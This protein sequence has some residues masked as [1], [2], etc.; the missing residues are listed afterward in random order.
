MICWIVGLIVGTMP[1]MG[2][3]VTDSPEHLA[4]G[5]I[6]MEGGCRAKLVQCLHV[7]VTNTGRLDYQGWWDV[8]DV[9][10]G[11]RL[12]ASD[13]YGEFSVGE[14]N[15]KAGETKDVTIWFNFIQPDNFELS[16]VSS[17]TR[18]F[19]YTVDIGEYVAPKVTGNLRVDM[20]ERTDDG[21]ILYGDYA[22]FR[23]TGTATLTN[24]DENTIF[25]WGGFMGGAGSGIQVAVSPQLFGPYVAYQHLYSLASELK[26]G[27]TVTKDFEF[28]FTATPEDGKDY[29]IYLDVLGNGVDQILFTVKPCTNTYWTADGHVKPL[30]VEAGQVLK[31]PCEA[32]AVDLRG[33]YEMNTV[34]SI[35]TSEANPNCLYFLGY[36]D[37]VPQGFTSKT[38]IIRDYEAKE[39]IIDADDDYFCPMP[40]KA[41]TALFNYTPVSEA[42]GPAS[43]YMSQIM[44][45][46]VILP[47]E[48]QQAWLDWINDTNQDSPFSNDQLRIAHFEGYDGASLMFKP[49]T[50]QTLQSYEPYLI[51]HIIPSPVS[52]FS[53]EVNIPSSRKAIQ[54]LPYTDLSFEGSTTSMTAD[55]KTYIWNCDKYHFYRNHDEL[56]PVRPFTAIMQINTQ[57]SAFMSQDLPEVL[58][59]TIDDKPGLPPTP[60]TAINTASQYPQAV[61]SLSGQRV[62]TAERVNGQLSAEGLKPGLYIVGGRK[63]VVK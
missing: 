2:A 63:I 18:L 17:G 28:E 36:L 43:S 45:G 62:G 12:G 60:I 23:I 31:V 35:D 51:Y 48:A 47:F 33:Q 7:E 41:K 46:T 8:R 4:F 29:G 16:I 52:F 15:V 37:N 22:H 49:V 57:A 27:Q 38:N 34:F 21:N 11:K 19:D 25:A 61:Y 20:L 59:Y 56:R 32:L 6:W 42:M 39:I 30:P 14:V 24:E 1:M 26:S 9:K 40:F 13:T 3:N 44:S 55:E 10:T 53:E 58:N 54:T 5:K 50:S